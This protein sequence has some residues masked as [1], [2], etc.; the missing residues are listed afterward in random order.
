MGVA[1][2]PT[3]QENVFRQIFLIAYS[4]GGCYLRFHCNF[5]F[6]GS[7]RRFLNDIWR[8]DCHHFYR[9]DVF[10]PP[11]FTYQAKAPAFTILVLIYLGGVP[12]DMAETVE[13][14]GKF[15]S[16]LFIIQ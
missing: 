14:T 10:A 15:L 8:N 1:V 7:G 6:N 4:K 9:A 12:D 2:L 13:Y 16:R 5:F 3:P 11:E